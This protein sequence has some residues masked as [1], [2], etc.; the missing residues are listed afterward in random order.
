M[1]FSLQLT[2]L[3]RSRETRSNMSYP[4]NIEIF[5]IM[6]RSL[7]LSSFYYDLFRQYANS[8]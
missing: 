2:A 7:T 6:E 1:K 3:M 5:C 8:P 4:Y